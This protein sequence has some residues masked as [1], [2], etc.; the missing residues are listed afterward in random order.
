MMIRNIAISGHYNVT[1][2]YT[3]KKR[4]PNKMQATQDDATTIQTITTTSGKTQA[5]TSTLQRLVRNVC[6]NLRKELTTKPQER[7][8]EG[9][10]HCTTRLRLHER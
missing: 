4:K 2:S 6:E 8:T 5:Y 1:T 10:E 3:T 9:T 7:R